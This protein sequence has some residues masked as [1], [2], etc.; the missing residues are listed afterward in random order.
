MLKHIGFIVFVCCLTL[1]STAQPVFKGGQPALD[2]FITTKIVYPEYSR[3]NCIAATI[4]V[5]FRLDAAGKVDTAYVQ[6]GPGIDL[7]EE[8]VRIVRMTSGKWTVP[9]TYAIGAVIVIPIT[10]TPDYSRC[11][12]V[13]NQSRQA[14]IANY[15]AQEQLQD[16]ITNYYKNKYQ[17]KGDPNVEKQIT[18]LKIQ[19]GYDDSFI[20]DLLDQANQKFKQGDKAGACKDWNFIRNIGSDKADSFIAKNCR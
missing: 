9:N 13:T 15:K 3:Q 20:N 14:A 10:F 7:D 2:N 5:A 11:N 19:L 17:G 4:K 6:D 8:A 16:A 12:N 1:R 18:A